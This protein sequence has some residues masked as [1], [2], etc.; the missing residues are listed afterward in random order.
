MI[1]QDEKS[2]LVANC[3][4]FENFKH[5]KRLPDAFTEQGVAMLSA[6]LRSETAVHFGASLKDLGKKWFAFSKMDIEAVE[7]LGK[8][9]KLTKVKID[10]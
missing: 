5:S 7:M 8:L 1:T 2:E 10:G 6:V 4:R 9:E 3:D